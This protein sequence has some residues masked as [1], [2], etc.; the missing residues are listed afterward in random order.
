[1]CWR[2]GLQIQ[3]YFGK[4]AF[5]F[6]SNGKMAFKLIHVLVKWPSSS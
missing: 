1:M 4:M 6:I 3:T 5:K 2:N